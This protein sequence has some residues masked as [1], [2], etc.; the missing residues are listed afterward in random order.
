MNIL[1]IS[2][3]AVSGGIFIM[4][5]WSTIKAKNKNN[6]AVLYSQF[7]ILYIVGLFLCF[8]KIYQQFASENL[9]RAMQGFGQILFAIAAINLIYIIKLIWDINNGR[10]IGSASAVT[11]IIFLLFIEFIIAGSSF[12]SFY[13]YEKS[14]N[15]VLDQ[16]KDYLYAVANSRSSHISTLITDYKKMILADSTANLGVI[17]CVEGIQ[18]NNGSCSKEQLDEMLEERVKS[19]MESDYL[20]TVLDK[21][22]Q[23]ISS[24]DNSLTG[25]DWSLR[26]AFINRTSEGYISDI[27]YDEKYNRQSI[28]ISHPIVKSGD[29]LGVWIVRKIPNDIYDVLQ[30]R[31]NLGDTGEAILIDTNGTVLSPQRFTGETF[32]KMDNSNVSGCRD[33]FDKYVVETPTSLIVNKHDVPVAEYTNKFGRGILGAHVVVEGLTKGLKWCV[34]LEIGEQEAFSSLNQNLLEALIFSLVIVII[35]ICIFIF[36]FDFFFRKLFKNS[37]N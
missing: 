21:N 36:T 28:E 6:S 7:F 35:L 22:G 16:Y 25:E 14:K 18:S 24:T 2:I 31:T 11:T 34:L 13:F 37:L 23:V 12:T 26:P 30:D 20:A 15:I 19:G 4:S 33:D 17:S 3:Y 8:L 1:I 32:T 27:F 10:K 9:V 29:F 5:I